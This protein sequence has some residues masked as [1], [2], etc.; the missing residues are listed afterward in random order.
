M[1]ADTLTDA[2]VSTPTPAGTFMDLRFYYLTPMQTPIEDAEL[3]ELIFE[4]TDG[5]PAAEFVDYNAFITKI[6]AL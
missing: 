6:L 3:E 4:A 5:N 1:S 2:D